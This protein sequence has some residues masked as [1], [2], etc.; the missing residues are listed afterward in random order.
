MIFLKDEFTRK[1]RP[2]K[3][4]DKST[5]DMIINYKVI[6]SS[7][8]KKMDSLQN[9]NDLLESFHRHLHFIFP[10]QRILILI[11][12][13]QIVEILSQSKDFQ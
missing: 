10:N 6:L 7:L 13:S 5:D 3:D 4:S 1:Y 8:K 11:A 9:N 2:F 12:Y